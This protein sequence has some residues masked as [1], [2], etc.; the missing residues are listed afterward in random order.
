MEHL[1][2]L[3]AIKEYEALTSEEIQN[4]IKPII[5]SYDKEFLSNYLGVS[6]EHLY[7]ICKR[8]F[9]ENNER[10][11]FTTYIKIVALGKNPYYVEKIYKP[12]KKRVNTTP[13]ERKEALKEYQKKYY[14]EVTK[15]KRQE[16]KEKNGNK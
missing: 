4:E 5:K 3:E 12:R 2:I 16:K 13:E 7:R 9:V 1:K 14:K 6:K 11:Q 8:L 15:K 10:V